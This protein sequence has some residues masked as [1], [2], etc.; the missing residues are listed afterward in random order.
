MEKSDFLRIDRYEKQNRKRALIRSIFTFSFM[1]LFTVLGLGF[2]YYM[3]TFS[4]FFNQITTSESNAN[5][6]EKNDLIF[7]EGKPFSI[8]LLGTDEMDQNHNARTDTIIV[9]TVNP[10][11]ESVKMV[12]I[13]RDIPVQTPDGGVEK[14]NAMYSIGGTELITDTL[15]EMLEIPISFYAVIDFQGLINL[16]DAVGG[17]T[18]D[19]DLAFTVS[20]AK[21]EEDD[22]II[23]EGIQQ[24]NGEEALGYSRMRKD[25]PR[26]DFGR[27]DRQQEVIK[28][29]VDEAISLN[30]L[31]NLSPILKAIGPHLVT[32]L[33]A[34]HMV[35]IASEYRPALKEFNSL[36][37]EGEAS[38]MYFPHYGFRVWTFEPHKESIEAIQKD[39]QEHLEIASNHFYSN[40]F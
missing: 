40:S 15:E 20:N 23:Q 38:T 14:I 25:D 37:I 9:A 2:G 10:A 19:S 24:L 39:L 4:T 16:V 7:E 27:Q 3:A 35:E 12:S 1:I 8:A 29:I 21:Y 11:Q 17:I 36:S 6:A 34:D 33:T 31:V 32:D 18:V 5:Q 30:G 22:I 28:A 26:G 13:P